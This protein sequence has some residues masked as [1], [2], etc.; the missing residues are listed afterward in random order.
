MLVLRPDEEAVSSEADRT[1]F[2]A[3]TEL[4]ALSGCPC[5]VDRQEEKYVWP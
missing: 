5:A 2:F 3:G 1:T 4:A